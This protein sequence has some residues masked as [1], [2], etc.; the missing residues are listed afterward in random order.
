MKLLFFLFL[1]FIGG[2]GVA[3]N[4]YMVWQ[5]TFGGNDL[6]LG[7]F[8]IHSGE[9]F[10]L[11]GSSL[12][13]TSYE[14]SEDSKGERDVWVVKTTED[15]DLIWDKTIGGL[16]NDSPTSVKIFGDYIYILSSSDSP[17]SGDKTSENFDSRDFWLIC[18][19][20]DGNISWDQTYGGLES[21]NSSE[22]II[23]NNGNLLISGSTL[24]GISGNKTSESRGELD[25]WILEVSPSD[26]SIIR[27]AAF[28]TY[29]FDFLF[30][31]TQDTFGNIYLAG[32]S[33]SGIDGD[34][35][36]PGYGSDDVWILK[37]DEDWNIVSDK[38]FGGSEIEY[39]GGDL[40]IKNGFLYLF[41]DSE[42]PVSGNKTAPLYGNSDY[43]L[44]KMDLDLNIIWDVS[45]GGN[46]LDQASAIIDQP[47]DKL[48]L[49]GWSQSLVSGNKTAMRY[50]TSK[51]IWMIIVDKDGNEV[52]QET[53]GGL[54]DD[55]GGSVIGDDQGFLYVLGGSESNSGGVKTEDCRGLS[56]YWFLKLDATDFLTLEQINLENQIV[57]YPNPYYN[58][59][60]FEFGVHT[61][62]LI[63]S[64]YS[65]DGKKVFETI[66]PTEMSSYLWRSYNETNQLLIYEIRSNETVIT[67]KLLRMN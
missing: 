19:D 37:I 36:D 4:P 11:I 63:L 26:G 2:Q 20:Y 42:S 45:F 7:Y 59:V 60:Q 44:V 67:G 43:W 48:V 34:K 10:F 54:M 8:A 65:L 13:N 1:S 51:D 31:I 29:A 53:Y 38:C 22:I 21:D 14:K 39:P 57:V 30:D 58:Q 27:Q 47:S 5:H 52:R 24:S 46:Y 40:V 55:W 9:N 50:G 15:G 23:L 33:L 32:T 6:D 25:Y 3:Q 18:I 66:I 56:D 28:G 41:T 12:S 61:E 49:L 62:P 16:A 35:T 64:L 17:V